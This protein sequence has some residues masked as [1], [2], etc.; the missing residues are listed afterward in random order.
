MEAVR[1]SKML[2]SQRHMNDKLSSSAC[3]LLMR[4][5]LGG[6][7]TDSLVKNMAVTLNTQSEANFESGLGR[8][9]CA[10]KIKV[11]YNQN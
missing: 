6:F 1:E 4:Q 8:N 2:T 9:T 11:Q 3:L 7:K 5:S 10:L